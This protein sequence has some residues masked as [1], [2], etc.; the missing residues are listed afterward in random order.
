M[1]LVYYKKSVPNF[2]DDLNAELWP[3]LEPSLF[4]E[5]NEEAFVGIGTIIGM[6]MKSFKTLNVFSSGAGNDPIS[7]WKDY[8]VNFKAVRGP[9]SAA[10]LGLAPDVAASDGALLSPLVWPAPEHAVRN[11]IIMVPHWE[12][13][14]HPGWAEVE[15]LTGFRI[16]DPRQS[17]GKVIS[18]IYSARMVLT[19]SLHGAIIADTYGIPWIGFAT[20][21]NFSFG[22]WVDW[23]MSVGLPCELA[24][25]PPP[26]ASTVVQFGRLR[27]PHDTTVH[28]GK[29]EAFKSMHARM[30]PVAGVK[31]GLVQSLK[32]AIKNTSFYQRSL[33]LSPEKTA[34]SLL[35][36]SRRSGYL[37]SPEVRSARADDLL[38]RLRTMAATR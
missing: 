22:K 26:S 33:S 32:T 27:Y 1:K 30:D 36:L 29:E 2:G 14:E 34:E 17:P 13:L 25:V 23:A 28:F 16:V 8:K 38:Q 11:D 4:D 5:D 15:R 31:G 21:N 18:D 9:I 6:P 10:V 19:E 12:T 24:M 20:S 37:S 3:K 7:R 35:K